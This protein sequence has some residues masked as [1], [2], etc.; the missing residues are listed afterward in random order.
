MANYIEELDAG[1]REILTDN[2]RTFGVIDITGEPQ[3]FFDL[4]RPGA[5]TSGR[6]CSR[7]RSGR[8][9]SN[10]VLFDFAPTPGGL[11]GPSI[12]GPGDG[13]VPFLEPVAQN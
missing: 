6:R 4:R 10:A 1:T 8:S 2:A 3:I 11:P 13:D 9:S 5:T 7:I 12:P